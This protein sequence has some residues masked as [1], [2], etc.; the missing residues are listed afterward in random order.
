MRTLL[1]ELG[2]KSFVKTTGGK[3]LH[4]VVPLTNPGTIVQMFVVIQ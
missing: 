4:V 2:M 3:G 1:D